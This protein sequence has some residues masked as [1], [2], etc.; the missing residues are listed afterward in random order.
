MDLMLFLQYSQ[1][2]L[3]PWFVLT[4]L[5]CCSLLSQISI[6]Q[7]SLGFT[8]I[9]AS[10]TFNNF[11]LSFSFGP[12]NNLGST[13]QFFVELSDANG[14][15][16][17]PILL[18]T[19]N[20]TT[21]P[22]QINFGVPS[23]LSGQNFRIRIRSTSP[24]VL[25]PPSVPFAITYAPFNA[26]FTIN[27]GVSNVTACESEPFVLSVSAGA[28]S[29]LNFSSLNYQWFRNNVL[30]AGAT[31][32]SI[33]VTENGNYFARVN[34][35][36]C[37]FNAFSNLVSV[38]FVA[39]P[40]NVLQSNNSAICPSAGLLIFS[41]LSSPDFTY[42][43]YRNDELI[44]VNN[45]FE[46][47]ATSPGNY[48]VV[49]NNGICTVASN[50]LQLSELSIS[51]SLNFPETQVILPS[52]QII[53]EA[54][55][56]AQNPTFVWLKD[57]QVILGEISSTL[58]V[59]E[60]GDYRVKITQNT[61]CVLENELDVKVEFPTN[62]NLQISHDSNYVPCENNQQTLTIGTFNTNINQLSLNILSANIPLQYQWYKDNVAI[63]N[64]SNS[65]FNLLDF[66][67]NGFYYLKI[68]LA[69]NTEITSNV[70]EVKLKFNIQTELTSEGIICDEDSVISIV[71]SINDIN[72][73]YQWFRLGSN[74][75]LS[76]AS[77][78]LVNQPGEYFVVISY[79]GCGYTSNN[80]TI[81]ALDKTLLTLNFEDLVEISENENITF[82]ANGADTYE[83]YFNDN[84]ISTASSV[85]IN[86]AGFLEVFYFVEDC[87]VIKT[88]QIIVR[89][90]I[91]TTQIPNVI[92][93]NNDGINDYWILPEAYAFR[94]DVE[95]TIYSSDN[96]YYYQ[97]TNY[98]N[99]WPFDGLKLKN[100]IYYYVI[101]VLKT[102]IRGTLTLLNA[103]K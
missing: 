14:V 59:N 22:V 53:L 50:V 55:T 83:W 49:V 35:G 81:N 60:P 26:P 62:Y 64:A 5:F 85:T 23:T 99:N 73:Q 103:T 78:C 86:T 74:N 51:S 79:L 8:Q 89:P 16:T 11:N 44:G 84:L 37:I 101:K 28:N 80:I 92:T 30:I 68:T 36:S 75:V 67:N 96:Q 82:I 21:S 2:Y 42:E 41:S 1:R 47:I 32:S 39:G 19:S 98:Q 27:N 70:L 63:T 91:I 97:S 102:T 52:Q 88:I 17:N 13:N 77:N 43:W 54:T 100:Q 71:S 72:Y 15:F 4:M 58:T 34:Y 56:T 31:S 66:N 61:D 93:P 95:I 40:N 7:P 57:D 69:D 12:V 10:A 18:T 87:V 29:P 48:K 76:T 6:N 94:D 9:C 3:K 20:A 24:A 90:P 45:L 65:I 38:N 46:L 25:S 33:Q